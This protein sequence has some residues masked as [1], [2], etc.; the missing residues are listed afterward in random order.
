M[1]RSGPAGVV[2][3]MDEGD[4]AAVAAGVM[5]A[6]ADLAAAAGDDAAAVDGRDDAPCV[7]AWYVAA[8]EQAAA[9]SAD[10]AMTARPL[11]FMRRSPPGLGQ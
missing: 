1:S 2:A 8:P 9:A 4:A 5:V 10:A 11:S 6:G 7:D 3:G